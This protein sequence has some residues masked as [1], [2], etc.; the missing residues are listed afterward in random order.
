M[1]VYSMLGVKVHIVLRT[2]VSTG[3]KLTIDDSNNNKISVTTYLSGIQ[4]GLNYL[5][6][7]RLQGVNVFQVLRRDVGIGKELNSKNSNQK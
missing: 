3:N 5:K 1:K 7:Y 2:E 6:M 4:R